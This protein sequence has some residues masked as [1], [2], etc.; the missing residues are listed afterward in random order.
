MPD[1]HSDSETQSY[2]EEQGERDAPDPRGEM[3]DVPIIPSSAAV[4]LGPR[5]EE[6]T[7]ADEDRAAAERR[8]RGAG[9]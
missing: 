3:A 9:G 2:R 6:P 1:R 4:P 8:D 7:T 5:A